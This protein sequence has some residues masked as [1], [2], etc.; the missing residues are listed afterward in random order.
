MGKQARKEAA[1]KKAEAARLQDKKMNKLM[2]TPK[3]KLKIP[4]PT[5]PDGWNLEQSPE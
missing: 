4:R 1:R 5:D 3:R 2:T